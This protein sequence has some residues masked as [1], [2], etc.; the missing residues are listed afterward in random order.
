MF[1]S[2]KLFILVELITNLHLSYSTPA[3]SNFEGIKLIFILFTENLCCISRP[4]PH[5]QNASG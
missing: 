3:I 1:N 4:V 2:L 5:I